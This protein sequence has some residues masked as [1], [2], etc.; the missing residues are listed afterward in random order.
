[1]TPAARQYPYGAELVSARRASFR[2]WAPDVAEVEVVVDGTA[3]PLA[4]E[5]SGCYS[6]TAVARAG[7]RYGFR[8]PGD[9][10]IYPDPA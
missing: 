8:V 10:R 9:D 3:T 6:G 2:V 7:S 5:D 4:R 1:M